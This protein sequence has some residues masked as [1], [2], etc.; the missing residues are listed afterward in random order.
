MLRGGCPA[1][2]KGNSGL[3]EFA[4]NGVDGAAIV[5]TEYLVGEVQAGSHELQPLMYAKA[6]LNVVL[7]VGVEVIVSGWPFQSQDRIVGSGVCLEIVSR[8]V[9]VVMADSKAPREPGL[10]VCQVEV[11]GVRRLALQGGVIDASTVESCRER[12]PG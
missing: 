2:A 7:R 4:L 8:D 10:V 9:G 6:S 5:E 3:I 12:D 11:P 1:E